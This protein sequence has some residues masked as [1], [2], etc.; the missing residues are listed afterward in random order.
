M[1]MFVSITALL[2]WASPAGAQQINV[3]IAQVRGSEAVIVSGHG[4]ARTAIALQ[5]I[6][7]IS[8][9]VPDVTVG[10]YT[11][12]TDANG[13]YRV[14]LPFAPDF[15]R[16]TYLTVVANAAGSEPVSARLLIGAPNAGAM[17]P[18]EQQTP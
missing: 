17:V 1:L 9:D 15:V 12:S 6:G 18:L 14:T 2:A 16:N 3:S 4:P 5:L 11:A 10:R 7:T 13:D 8:D